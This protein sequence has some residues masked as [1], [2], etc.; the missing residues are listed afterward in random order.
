MTDLN[1][2]FACNLSNLEEFSL[3]SIGEEDT[4]NQ[5][6]SMISNFL[7]MQIF[8]KGQNIPIGLRK[9]VVIAK[10]ILRNPKYVFIDE[11]ALDL[12][13]PNAW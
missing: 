3:D 5:E 13:F 12:E 6:Y 11:N 10:A 7:Q 2:K 4:P 1:L 8:N 9:M